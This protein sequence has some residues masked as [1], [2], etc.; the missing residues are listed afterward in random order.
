MMLETDLTCGS[1]N[2]AFSAASSPDRLDFETFSRKNTMSW[3]GTCILCGGGVS[4]RELVALSVG[5][6]PS[7]FIVSVGVGAL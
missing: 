4:A 5:G 6:C 7:M 2:A 3:V 1:R